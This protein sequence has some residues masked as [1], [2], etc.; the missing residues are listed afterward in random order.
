MNVVAMFPDSGDVA[1]KQNCEF[2][3]VSLREIFP[4]S[5]LLQP[6]RNIHFWLPDRLAVS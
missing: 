1:P 5:E 3:Y 6:R 4:F 2:F